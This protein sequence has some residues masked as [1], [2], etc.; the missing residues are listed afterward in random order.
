[1]PVAHDRSVFPLPLPS[2]DDHHLVR[3]AEDDIGLDEDHE[4]EDTQSPYAKIDPDEL[5]LVHGA[6]SARCYAL[7]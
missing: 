6:S 1:M 2:R 3:L 4:R 5:C 7:K